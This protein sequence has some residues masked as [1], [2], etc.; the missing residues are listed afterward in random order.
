MIL[1]PSEFSGEPG[2]WVAGRVV[3][4][5]RTTLLQKNKGKKG[6]GKGADQPTE[7]CEVHLLGGDSTS[8][9]L[10][11]EAWGEAAAAYHT[12]SPKGR[13]QKLQNAKVISQRPLFSSSRLPYF[14]RIVGQIG[15]KTR[16]Q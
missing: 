16:V 5:R 14:L 10:Y 15:I 11:V 3:C 8:E 12:L 1:P 9:V 4:V 2:T 7:K 13:L 6:K